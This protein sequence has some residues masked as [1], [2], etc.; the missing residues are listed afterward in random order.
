M[1]AKGLQDLVVQ[2]NQSEM[3]LLRRAA[4]VE[5]CHTDRVAAWAKETLLRSAGS[6]TEGSKGQ[7]DVAATAPNS[8][9]ECGCGAT[10]SPNGKC[11]GTCV[12]QF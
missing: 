1:S 3:E 9:P 7:T 10:G 2:L 11:D 8:R 4:L 6:Q 12:L 5:G